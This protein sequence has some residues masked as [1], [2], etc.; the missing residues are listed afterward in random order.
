MIHE[1]KTEFQG[2]GTTH[3][4]FHGD[5]FK[6][7]NVNYPGQSMYANDSDDDYTG[8]FGCSTYG[9]DDKYKICKVDLVDQG[10]PC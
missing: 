2:D 9:L 1:R 5:T 6:L 7:E 3:E 10:Y 4:L 8:N